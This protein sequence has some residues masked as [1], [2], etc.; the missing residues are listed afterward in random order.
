MSCVSFSLMAYGSTLTN[1][2][3]TYCKGCAWYESKELML[4]KTINCPK[5]F[6][7]PQKCSI[8]DL[9]DSGEWGRHFQDDKT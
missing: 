7:K 2:H 1:K 6:V 3:K 8:P 9:P 5:C 4:S